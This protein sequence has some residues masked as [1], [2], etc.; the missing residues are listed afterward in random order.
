[1]K[2]MEAR[3]ERKDVFE[4]KYNNRIPSASVS[5]NN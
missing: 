2:A 3:Q 5:L 1:M 4:K